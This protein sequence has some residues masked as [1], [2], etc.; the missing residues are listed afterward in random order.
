MAP[1]PKR[2]EPPQVV[3]PERVLSRA[4]LW[5][6]GP[7]QLQL[8]FTA[9]GLSERIHATGHLKV[10]PDYDVFAWLCERWQTR[11][12][13]SGWMRPTYYEI[14]CSLYGRA[15]SNEDYRSVREA[16]DRLAGVSVTIDGYDA[17]T[18]T[19][20]DPGRWV[21]KSN[22][23]EISTPA[24]DPDGLDRWGFRLAEWLRVALDSGQVVRVPWGILRRFDERQKLAKRL[25]IYLQAE[26]FKAAGRTDHGD[27]PTE[28]CW[29][30]CGDRLE[31]SLSMSYD[32]PRAAR[33]A[34]ARACR[35]VREVD[36][37]YLAGRLE[38]ESSGRGRAARH[39][40][41]AERPTWK[42]W[43][44]HA[45]EWAAARVERESIR[46]S[47]RADVVA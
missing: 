37:R 4:G 12:T 29:I 43:R 25:W 32:R 1:M 11:P 16:L 35:T 13:K 26:R 6:T 28:G 44:E 27:M 15:P 10:T 21:T 2:H 24:F 38:L 36:D 40:I 47:L 9:S 30:A 20:H 41:Y 22:L 34:L 8:P 5:A 18:G 19:Y 17:I 23:V 3:R 45:P 39:R 46:A 33:A 7:V 31:A 42:A 14:G